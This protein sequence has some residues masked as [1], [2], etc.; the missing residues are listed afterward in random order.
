MP[1]EGHRNRCR[2]GGRILLLVAALIAIPFA[3]GPATAQDAQA[4]PTAPLTEKVRVNLVQV[5]LL[6][7]ARG[8]RAVTDLRADEIVVKERGRRMPVV[9]LEPLATPMDTADIPGVSLPGGTQVSMRA[10]EPRL[11]HAIILVERSEN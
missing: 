7:R 9:F 11:R 8:G 3:P 4:E 1:K 10:G 2:A 5:P 6:A